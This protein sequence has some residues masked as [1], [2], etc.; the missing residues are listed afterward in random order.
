MIKRKSYAKIEECYDL[1]NLLEIQLH[2]YVEFLQM[3]IPKTKRK[4]QGLES[5]FR[6]VFPIQAADG[7][8]KLEYVSYSI[9]KP[10]YTLLECK[11][12]GMTYGGALRV[13]MRLKSKT[14]TKEQEVYLGDIPLMTD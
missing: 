6:E 7:E 8:H 2:S 13:M 14:E 3:D 10:K 11:K 4:N 12:R 5:A 9:G 1:P